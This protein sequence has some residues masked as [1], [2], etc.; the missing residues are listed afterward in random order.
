MGFS[1]DT[2]EVFSSVLNERREIFIFKSKYL[3]KT[4]STYVIYLTD[5]EFSKFR[6]SQF[7]DHNPDTS[8][9]VII[10]GIPNTDRRRD[11]LYVN[12]ADKFL[13]FIEV[14][15]IPE[16]EKNLKVCNRILYGHSIAGSFVMYSMLSTPGIFDF[17]IASSP[18]P[19]VDLLSPDKFMEMD[20]ISLKPIR[21]YFSCGSEDL[22]QVNKGYL[23]LHQNIAPCIFSKLR[24]KC[25]TFEGKN[26]NDS[27]ISALINGFKWFVFPE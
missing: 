13:K 10:I 1:I 2:A 6:C 7:F 19:M 3:A 12:E 18:I 16:V 14:E 24:W 15:L 9:T 21:F 25:E 5:G 23:K 22:K 4:D 26:H 11:L 20:R 27:D 8:R 17:Y